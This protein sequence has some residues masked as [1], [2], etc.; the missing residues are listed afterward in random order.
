MTGDVHLA[1]ILMAWSVIAIGA[2]SPGPAV[3][4]IM[5]AALERGRRPAAFLASGVVCGSLFWGVMAA[6]GLS[7][8]LSRFGTA[9]VLLKIVGGLYLLWLASKAL[10]AAFADAPPP[11][12][13]VPNA[14][15]DRHMW[16]TGLLIHLTNPKGVFGWLA[17]V[18]LG[19]TAEAPGWVAVVIVAGGVTISA[20]CH[21]GY[22]LLFSTPGA[23][24]LYARARRA[25]QFTLAAIFGAAGLRL[26]LSRA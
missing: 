21:G 6:A 17:M 14:R 22:A 25:I 23:A 10:R 7:A 11:P 26:L 5:G 16:L 19:M 13:S 18:A 12:P 1:G 9:L 2:L 24:R 4:A 20:I 15:R 8:L 3:L